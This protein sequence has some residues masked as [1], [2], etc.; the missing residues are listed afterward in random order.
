MLMATTD[1]VATVNAIRRRVASRASPP[2]RCSATAPAISAH[3]STRLN[4]AATLK[5]CGKFSGHCHSSGSSTCAAL[6]P[7]NIH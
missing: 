6:R 3:A 7:A 1:N 4:A 5:P 2:P